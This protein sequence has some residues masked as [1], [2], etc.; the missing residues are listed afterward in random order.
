[1]GC[2]TLAMIQETFLS[3]PITYKDL[4]EA[5]KLIR[6]ALMPEVETRNLSDEA[7][8]KNFADTSPQG[9][10]K[11][12]IGNYFFVAEN[13]ADLQIIGVIG[14]RKNEGSP[15]HNRVS[16]FNVDP[17]FQGR[18]VGKLLYRQV[19]RIAI[20][21]GCTKLVVSSSLSAEPIYTHWGFLKIREIWHEC[22]NND[23][24]RNIW[25]EKDL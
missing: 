23:R 24:Y 11:R 10:A 6:R 14:L 20:K 12:I 13:I 7:I 18:G 17:H 15:I 4:G 9:L 1:M 8:E 25:M 5:S 22:G 19:E 21:L 16:T 2:Y 3:R